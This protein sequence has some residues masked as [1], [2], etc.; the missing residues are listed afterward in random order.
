MALLAIYESI[1]V[2]ILTLYGEPGYPRKVVEDVVNFMDNFIR[3]VYL[4]SL[5]NDIISTLQQNNIPVDDITKCFDKYEN[6]FSNFLTKHKRLKA[7]KEKG[8][9][10][11]EQFPIGK[12]FVREEIGNNKARLVEKIKYAVHIPLK[13][14][15]KRFLQIPGMFQEILNYIDS[16]KEDLKIVTNIIQ[17]NLW[18]K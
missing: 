13:K 15:L 5:K 7:L 3:N 12:E 10:D 2:F 18:I 16:L 4:A 8:L 6:V 9:I 17:G 11:Y 14:S 1:L